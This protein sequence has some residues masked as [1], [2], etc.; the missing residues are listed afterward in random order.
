MGMKACYRFLFVGEDRKH[1]RHVRQFQ[2]SCDAL[3]RIQEFEASTGRFNSTGGTK[4]TS[5]AEAADKRCTAH[6]H[7]KSFL[8]LFHKIGYESEKR[9]VSTFRCQSSRHIHYADGIDLSGPKLC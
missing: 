7:E 3:R 9:V 6:V 1:T 4:Q 5:N 2:D 8:T